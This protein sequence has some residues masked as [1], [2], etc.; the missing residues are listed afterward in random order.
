M[1]VKKHFPRSLEVKEIVWR[2]VLTR[3]ERM[4]KKIITCKRNRQGE[5]SKIAVNFGS[6][7]RIM[8]KERKRRRK[9]QY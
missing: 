1:Q 2:R 8:Q 3:E 5:K 6:E 7:D 9:K 4:K